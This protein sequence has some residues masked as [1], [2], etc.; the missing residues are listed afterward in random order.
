MEILFVGAASSGKSFLIRK[1]K[2]KLDQPTTAANGNG[3]SDGAGTMFKTEYT[4]PTV[5]VDLITIEKSKYNQSVVRL[6]EI[7]SPMLTKWSSY[8]SDCNTA[9]V[10]VI[11]ISD[12][13]SFP[14]SYIL[15]LEVIS[16]QQDEMNQCKVANKP[17]TPKTIIL[18]CNKMDM[19]DDSYVNDFIHLV[20]LNELQLIENIQIVIFQ[21]S[22]LE[23]TFYRSDEEIS[24]VDSVIRWMDTFHNK[25]MK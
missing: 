23:L 17:Y 22:C 20:R 14:S 25:S 9:I 11:D 16:Y 21:G 10:L 4:K 8:N 1:L 2:E 12:R 24:L 15:L 7:G 13:G 18:A 19:A 3:T 6:R 5:G